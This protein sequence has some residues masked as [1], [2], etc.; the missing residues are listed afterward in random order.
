M[1]KT[2]SLLT[3]LVLALGIT[4]NVAMAG[5]VSESFADSG[6]IDIAGPAN[7]TPVMQAASGLIRMLQDEPD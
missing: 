6:T 1:F 4:S 5:P 7:E 3:V 2:L